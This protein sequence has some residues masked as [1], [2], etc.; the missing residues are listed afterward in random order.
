MLTHYHIAID[1]SFIAQFQ[2]R[3]NQ[4]NWLRSMRLMNSTTP[5]LKCRECGENNSNFAFRRY[6]VY[7]WHFSDWRLN[8]K[9]MYEILNTDGMVQVHWIFWYKLIYLN[10]LQNVNK[11]IEIFLGHSTDNY[12]YGFFELKVYDNHNSDWWNMGKL[13]EI[14]ASICFL[15]RHRI[16]N[17]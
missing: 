12:L 4:Y 5:C 14:H 6:D 16:S 17:S 8:L 13:G 10:G 9:C 3:C 11:H 1:P 7:L 2:V 15:Y